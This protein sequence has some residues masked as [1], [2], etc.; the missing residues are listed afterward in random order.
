M[1]I[2][3]LETHSEK[4]TPTQALPELPV[5]EW[6]SEYGNAAAAA[7]AVPNKVYYC[8]GDEHPIS[9]AVHL[10]RLA[11]YY[12]HCAQ[13]PLRND[14]GQ[15]ETP[16]TR[17][18]Q[19]SGRLTSLSDLC[20]TD[21]FRGIHRNQLTRSLAARV[22][23]GFGGLL[24]EQ[25]GLMPRVRTNTK[26]ADV[27]S[28]RVPVVPVV[29]VGYDERPWSPELFTG[30]VAGIRRMGCAVI[31]LGL[32]TRPQIWFACHHL[33]AAG[34]VHVTGSGEG[35]S[36]TGIDLIAR[37]AVPV[38]RR[39]QT[40]DDLSAHIPSGLDPR[41]LIKQT[42][43]LDRLLSYCEQPSNRFVRR[44]D[45]QRSFRVA[46]PYETGLWK[47][48]EEGWRNQV[49][50]GTSSRLIR[51]SWGRLLSR[52]SV[53]TSWVD[54]PTRKR[55]LT[56]QD[57]DVRRVSQAVVDDQAD[58]GVLVS[59][60]AQ[61]CLIVDE[62]GRTLSPETTTLLLA[63]LVNSYQGD[64]PIVIS[65]TCRAFVGEWLRRAGIEVRQTE[66]KSLSG[67]SSVVHEH[68]AAF[69]C[70]GDHRYWYHD[71]YASCDATWVFA[72]LLRIVTKSDE[73]LSR[74]ARI[75]DHGLPLIGRALTGGARR[76]L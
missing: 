36:Y 8:P 75:N 66:K 49:V 61:Q 50:V 38:S 70:I 6:S 57:A 21:G 37:R 19:Q 33:E 14:S 15:L 74:I 3:A 5:L 52:T 32:V 71:E 27:C 40:A 62:T 76:G 34:A 54:L 55:E 4:S 17:K 29:V 20:R 30:M 24:W 43:T 28:V 13:C 10:A 67:V 39:E 44:S 22:G 7:R 26:T 60:D 64:R 16:T 63:A 69:G 35:P 51:E 68:E 53:Q 9:R 47:W 58:F 48:F 1:G 12:P 25:T 42:P 59:D 23:S 73:P 31:E 18:L 72:Q 2:M 41:S 56:D 65:E 11:A 46:T 45:S